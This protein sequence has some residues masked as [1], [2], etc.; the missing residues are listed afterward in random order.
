LPKGLGSSQA[1]FM[2]IARAAPDDERSQRASARN[3]PG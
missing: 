2:A 1:F 3:T